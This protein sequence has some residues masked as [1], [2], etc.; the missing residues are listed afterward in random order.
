M[1]CDEPRSNLG[2][3]SRFIR[4]SANYGVMDNLIAF[5]ISNRCQGKPCLPKTATANP[6]REPT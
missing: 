1:P 4:Y 2:E 6:V 5:L 3:A